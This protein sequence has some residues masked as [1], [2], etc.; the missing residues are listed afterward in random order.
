MQR[1]V[2]E[3]VIFQYNSI[4]SSDWSDIQVAEI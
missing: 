2:D 4:S 3:L 1:M